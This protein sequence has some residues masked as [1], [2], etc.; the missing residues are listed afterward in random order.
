MLCS[1]DIVYPYECLFISMTN[2]LPTVTPID[3]SRRHV[4]YA[5]YT[6]SYYSENKVKHES[7]KQCMK[8]NLSLKLLDL[9]GCWHRYKTLGSRKLCFYEVNSFQTGGH[10][11]CLN[12]DN[13]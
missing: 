2:N 12:M 11:V 1:V 4:M 8:Y 3:P 10:V 6:T 5:V 7:S 9:K 13:Y